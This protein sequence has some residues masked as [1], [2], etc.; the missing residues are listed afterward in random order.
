MYRLPTRE[1]V[2]LICQD[3]LGY[4]DD[5]AAIWLYWTGP[6]FHRKCVANGGMPTCSMYKDEDFEELRLRIEWPNGDWT[7]CDTE[8]GCNLI[9]Y[10]SLCCRHPEMAEEN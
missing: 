8:T 7:T 1:Q 3:V 5:W 2:K 6:A 10:H 9:N 4:D